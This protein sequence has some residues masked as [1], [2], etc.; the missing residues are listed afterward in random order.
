MTADLFLRYAEGIDVGSL[1]E[2]RHSI[3]IH[4]PI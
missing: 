4:T 2:R 3:F 1:A